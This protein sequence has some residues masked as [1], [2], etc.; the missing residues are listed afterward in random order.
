MLTGNFRPIWNAFGDSGAQNSSPT[1][2]I[3]GYFALVSSNF[4]HCCWNSM[5]WETFLHCK[6]P[7]E[8]R[9]IKNSTYCL[10]LFKCFEPVLDDVIAQGFY[11]YSSPGV[12]IG[13]C[14]GAFMARPVQS[15]A[16][17]RVQPGHTTCFF[18]TNGGYITSGCHYKGSRVNL[19]ER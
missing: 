16:A 9:C 11:S 2:T 1:W 5:V 4:T 7:L 12:K 8:I 17:R 14:H 3:P 13:A 18:S 15:V 10:L 19:G 6:C